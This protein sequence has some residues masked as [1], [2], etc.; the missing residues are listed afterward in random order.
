M[1]NET[2]RA[3]DLCAGAGGWACA[4]R[5]APIEIVAA[6]DRWP[7]AAKTYSINH[8]KT[9]VVLADLL[10]PNAVT[11]II[12]THRG[13]VDLVL[14]GIPCETISVYR[15]AWNP[16]TKPSDAEVRRFRDLLDNVLRSGATRTDV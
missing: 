2:I 10:S 4:A 6:Y 1:Q 11:D 12:R 8:P 7:E 5:G 14:G 3:I 15:R 13:E 16:K 9:H